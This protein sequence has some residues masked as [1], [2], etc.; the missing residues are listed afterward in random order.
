MVLARGMDNSQY[1][2]RTCIESFKCMNLSDMNTL[3]NVDIRGGDEM[4]PSTRLTP[5]VLP[6]AKSS[7]TGVSVGYAHEE[8]KKWFVFRASYGRVDRAS[9]VMINDGTYAY[10]ARRY[11]Q[12]LYHGKRKKVL[13]PLIPNLV[14]AY[15][16]EEKANEY[17]NNTP[18]LSFLS[19]Y[20]N[21][22]E[23]DES[24]K[25]PPLT[26]SDAEMMRFILA[27]YHHNEH[28]MFVNESQC[29]YKSG[30]V[31]KVTDGLFRG[32][33]GRVARVAGQQR[34]ILSLSNIGLVA[35]AYIP[36]AFIEKIE[37]SSTN[38]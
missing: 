25:N 9:E 7:K 5:D 16:S 8:G 35:T 4:P 12:K 3:S 6:E 28:L 21:H 34:V 24:R 10:V 1:A 33:E 20:Y 38:T 29:H 2:F 11:V 13:V 30:D 23:F 14:F 15:T 27:T 26:I 19:Y 31:V 22:F 32:V 36:T 17:V 18:A 37:T